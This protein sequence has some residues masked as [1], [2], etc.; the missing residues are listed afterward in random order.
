MKIRDVTK[1]RGPVLQTI[2]CNRSVHEAIKNLVEHKIGSMPVLDSEGK[3]VGIITERDVLRLCSGDDLAA[4]VGLPVREVMTTELVIGF[5]DDGI[6]YALS[7]MTERRIRHM[8]IMEGGKLVAMISIGDL[9]KAI[10]DESRAEAHFLRDYV[11]G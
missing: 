10:G 1:D 7:V 9:V 8:P 11:S 2:A 6:D 4:A 3:L 5:P